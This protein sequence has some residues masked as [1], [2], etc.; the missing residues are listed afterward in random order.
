MHA[1][2]NSLKVNVIFATWFK[3]DRTSGRQNEKKTFQLIKHK[4]SK[5][6]Q[7]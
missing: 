1:I 5:S 3:C 4:G 2:V 7:T 6:L